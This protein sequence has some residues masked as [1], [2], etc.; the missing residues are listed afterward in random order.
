MMPRG[1][2]GFYDDGYYYLVLPREKSKTTATAKRREDDNKCINQEHTQPVGTH[3]PVRCSSTRWP[4]DSSDSHSLFLT[5]S[6]RGR[7]IYLTLSN[8]LFIFFFL[9][10]FFLIII[11]RE[12]EEK[13][14]F[15]LGV[16]FFLLGLYK[17][18]NLSTWLHSIVL[19]ASFEYLNIFDTLP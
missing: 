2:I 11:F 10:I 19:R 14:V 9:F 13:N 3:H 18:G 8:I 7:K 16:F 12:E 17:I 15:L 1:G 6:I 4:C 5:A